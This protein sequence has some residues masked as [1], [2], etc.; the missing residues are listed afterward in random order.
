MSAVKRHLFFPAKSTRFIPALR[1]GLTMFDFK[2]Y[3]PTK[4]D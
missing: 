2:N 4:K 3:T 1:S